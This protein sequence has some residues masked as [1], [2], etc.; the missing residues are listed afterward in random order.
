MWGNRNAC[1]NEAILCIGT[2]LGKSLLI[3]S[4][5][6]EAHILLLAINYMPGYMVHRNSCTY[7]WDIFKYFDSTSF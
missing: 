5:G 6:E 7:V 1:F 3:L 4:Y 2:T